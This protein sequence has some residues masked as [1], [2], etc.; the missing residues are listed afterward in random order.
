MRFLTGIGKGSGKV[1]TATIEIV[2]KTMTLAEK[3][4]KGCTLYSKTPTAITN[5]LV[6][7]QRVHTPPTAGSNPASMASCS[8]KDTNSHCE[9]A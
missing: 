1:L 9:I 2:L 3:S 4:V 6:V 7:K 5:S 8:L